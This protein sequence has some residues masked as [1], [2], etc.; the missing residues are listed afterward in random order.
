MTSIFLFLL[1]I[2]SVS[3]A[4]RCEYFDPTTQPNSC[5]ATVSQYNHTH[6]DQAEL[7]NFKSFLSTSSVSS[8]HLLYQNT[9]IISTGITSHLNSIVSL[10]QTFLLSFASILLSDS[11]HSAIDPF[12]SLLSRLTPSLQLDAIPL[13][14]YLCDIM[15]LR[16]FDPLND[17]YWYGPN[18]TVELA[19]KAFPIIERFLE[20]YLGDNLR[21]LVQKTGNIFGLETFR[22]DQTNDGNKLI[23]STTKD[24]L[25]MGNIVSAIMK[26]E[27]SNFSSVYS[28]FPLQSEELERVFKE[29]KFGW[30]INGASFQGDSSNL[31]KFAPGDTIGSLECTNTL[32]IA[33]SWD[34]VMLIQRS[35]KSCENEFDWLAEDINI[36]A[37]LSKVYTGKDEDFITRYSLGFA[38]SGVDIIK[39][40]MFYGLYCIVGHVVTSYVTKLFWDFSCMLSSKTKFK[41]T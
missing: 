19:R 36:W 32:Y 28:L 20:E 30:W 3:F 5:D 18:V 39:N 10:R 35:P 12:S 2:L 13:D 23:R 38:I 25:R 9:L 24:L 31:I 4:S 1:S 26:S 16:I 14:T 21:H 15:S 7:E 11:S 34:M 22:L 29:F 6:I 8:F 17:Q 41:H 40:F 33:P 37:K 27:F